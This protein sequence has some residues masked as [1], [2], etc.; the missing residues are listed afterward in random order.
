MA[1]AL[2]DY[3]IRLECTYPYKD[4]TRPK[5]MHQKSFV[6]CDCKTGLTNGIDH[7]TQYKPPPAKQVPT[8][9]SGERV[10]IRSNPQECAQC[11]RVVKEQNP[12]LKWIEQRKLCSS[13][14]TRQGCST[15]QVVVCQ[16]HWNA[17]DHDPTRYNRDPTRYND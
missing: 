5:W 1:I 16:G 6:P 14:K 2:L 3:A 8:A 10:N 11:S 13:S 9:C 7:K 4:S 12:N 15:C 17:F